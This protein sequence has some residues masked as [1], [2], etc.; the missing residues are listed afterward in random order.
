MRESAERM[1]YVQPYS[2]HCCGGL[3]HFDEQYDSFDIKTSATLLSSLRCRYTIAQTADIYDVI[4][5]NITSAQHT[6]N[7]NNEI[8]WIKPDK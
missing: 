7:I 4:A 8:P 3:V 5:R 1:Y 6:D 2:V